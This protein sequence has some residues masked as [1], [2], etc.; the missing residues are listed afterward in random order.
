MTRGITNESCL[1]L[2]VL[3]RT[4]FCRLSNDLQDGLSCVAVKA[5][6]RD[7]WVSLMIWSAQRS[8]SW[9]AM[10]KVGWS[11]ECRWLGCRVVDGI[12]VRRHLGAVFGLL[13][14][15]PPSH[16]RRGATTGFGQNR[17]HRSDTASRF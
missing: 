13:S 15:I 10:M 6:L 14:L 3:C 11:P 1:V 12:F 17:H 9:A 2:L 16:R 8:S 5:S 4:A 7:I